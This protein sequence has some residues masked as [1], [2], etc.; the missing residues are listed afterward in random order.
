MGL[1][2]DDV[3]DVDLAADDRSGMLRS[4]QHVRRDGVRVL[5]VRRGRLVREGDERAS[6]RWKYAA[7]SDNVKYV[8]VYT[9]I[10]EMLKA[11]CNFRSSLSEYR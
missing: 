11:G 8:V 10:L 3:S 5:R 6:S 4:S 9:C 1:L 7:L 2:D